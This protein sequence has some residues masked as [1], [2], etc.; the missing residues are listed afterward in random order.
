MT[1]LLER[2]IQRW[3]PAPMHRITWEEYLAL[4]E[5]S[6]YMAPGL[7]FQPTLFPGLTIDLAALMG[8]TITDLD[9][10][11]LEESNQ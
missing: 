5:G 1:A 4:P 6:P 9:E 2:P 11:E 8:E 3:P 10:T 7:P